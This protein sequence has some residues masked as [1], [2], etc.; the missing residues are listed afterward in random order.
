MSSAIPGLSEPFLKELAER[1]LSVGK[2]P[3]IL[4]PTVFAGEKT[5][6]SKIGEAEKSNSE[7]SRI[8]LL[9]EILSVSDD[10]NVTDENSY[11]QYAE[12]IPLET[13]ASTPTLADLNRSFLRLEKRLSENT[14]EDAY[15][16]AARLCAFV[17]SLEQDFS[18]ISPEFLTEVFN[19]QRTVA[20]APLASAAE[21]KDALKLLPFFQASFLEHLLTRE[22]SKTVRIFYKSLLKYFSKEVGDQSLSAILLKRY[23]KFFNER[24]RKAIRQFRSL[25]IHIQR[26]SRFGYEEQV[27]KSYSLA[28]KNVEAL[29]DFGSFNLTNGTALVPL[30]ECYLI[31]QQEKDKIAQNFR[32]GYEERLVSILSNAPLAQVGANHSSNA[33]T[34]AY[35]T[36]VCVLRDNSEVV[37][38]DAAV[39]VNGS[40]YPFDEFDTLFYCV[41][42]VRQD[43]NNPENR[44]YCWGFRMFSG[45]EVRLRFDEEADWNEFSRR[46][47]YSGFAPIAERVTEILRKGGR[48]HFK[49]VRITDLGIELPQKQKFWGELSFAFHPWKE[50]LIELSNST[51]ILHAGSEK[52]YIDTW[53]EDYITNIYPLLRQQANHASERLSDHIPILLLGEEIP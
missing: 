10:P 12:K 3:S 37:L 26:A 29:S 48:L 42:M 22:D 51:V 11:L 14:E 45:K 52:A 43:P 25:L 44:I 47:K 49:G 13:P 18:K 34:E 41:S 5:P 9:S 23:S 30:D 21:V 50:V 35:D 40:V 32:S 38:T 19:R 7:Y 33:Q 28:E 46:F 2:I 36:F 24:I 8:R 6:Y 53:E 4:N 15:R 16:K 27:R 31:W 20:E 1:K 17:L 39:V